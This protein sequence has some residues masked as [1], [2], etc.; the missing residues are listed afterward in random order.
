MIKLLKALVM[1]ASMATTS[2]VFAQ[3][4]EKALKAYIAKDYGVAMKEWRFLAE[5]GNADA[6]HWLGR[7]YEEGE[8]VIKDYKEAVYWLRKAS[9][10]GEAAA[11]SNLAAMY[12]FG[13]G[14]EQSKI[15][16]YMWWNVAAANGFRNAPKFRDEMEQ[17]LT[18]AE[19]AK[20]QDMARQ[21]VKKQYKGC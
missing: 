16:A 4:Y 20:A 5:R 21:C 14:V 2:A 19:I 6:Q 1:V 7:M 13:H 18:L 15:Y 17:Q 12:H 9:E 3:D 10:Q 11:Q 8:G